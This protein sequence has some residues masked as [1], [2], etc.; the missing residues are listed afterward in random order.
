MKIKSY[1]ITLLFIA[2]FFFGCSAVSIAAPQTTST[3]ESKKLERYQAKVNKAQ[4]VVLSNISKDINRLQFY[5]ELKSNELIKYIV[6]FKINYNKC[7]EVNNWNISSKKGINKISEKFW[8]GMLKYIDNQTFA[9]KPEYATSPTCIMMA[10]EY[11]NNE[12]IEFFLRKQGYKKKSVEKHLPSDTYILTYGYRYVEKERERL[13]TS[14]YNTKKEAVNKKEEKIAEDAIS[15]CKK[16]YSELAEP[17][18]AF[19]KGKNYYFQRYNAAD[20]SNQIKDQ[21]CNITG[22]ELKPNIDGSARITCSDLN[23]ICNKFLKANNLLDSYSSNGAKREFLRF[24]SPLFI[25][26]VTPLVLYKC[27]Y[28]TTCWV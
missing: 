10:F 23:D 11:K 19:L 9:I 3:L 12:I 28:T 14:L 2:L 16:R 26:K 21:W 15:Y 17:Y 18:R 7:L 24:I 20:G 6:N 25:D 13:F 8:D 4:K 5:K 22:F 1:R 27:W